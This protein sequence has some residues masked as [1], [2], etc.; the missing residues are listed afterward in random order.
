M[1]YYE[2]VASILTGWNGKIGVPPK[3]IHLLREISIILILV[4]ICFSTGW[5]NTFG[6]MERAPGVTGYDP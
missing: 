3:V 2:T 1:F 4:F 5:S 6:K